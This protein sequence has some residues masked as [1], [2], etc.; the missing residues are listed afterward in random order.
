M[1]LM[2]LMKERHHFAQLISLTSCSKLGRLLD[3]RHECSCKQCDHDGGGLCFA[4]VELG[5][6]RCLG[7]Q[8]MAAK[9]NDAQAHISVQ[10]CKKFI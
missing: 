4:T 2:S 5:G 9:C 1:S 6:A 3:E 10:C 7:V 8:D